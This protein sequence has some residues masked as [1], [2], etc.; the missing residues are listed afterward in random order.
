MTANAQKPR[1]FTGKHMLALF[2]GG[3]GIIISVNFG[4]AYM[5]VS[6]FRVSKRAAPMSLARPSR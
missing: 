4:M 1:E 5:A 6:T 3:F 2:V